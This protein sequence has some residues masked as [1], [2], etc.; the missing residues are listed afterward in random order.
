[1]WKFGS[2]ENALVVVKRIPIMRSKPS[3][4]FI[5]IFF[6]YHYFA[7]ASPSGVRL[8]EKYPS[9]AFSDSA[10][11]TGPTCGV[12]P[13]YITTGVASLKVGHLGIPAPFG[14]PN[15]AKFVQ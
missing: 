6:Y 14:S 11:G 2:C 10:L 13:R 15:L 12:G 3:F 7:Q 8:H 1:M 5:F 4:I 9:N